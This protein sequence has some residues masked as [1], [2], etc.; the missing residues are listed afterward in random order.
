MS[1]TAFLAVVCGCCLATT[2]SAD[3]PAPGEIA[4]QIDQSLTKEVFTDPTK[5][6]PRADDATFLR[7]VWLDIAGDIPTAEQVTAF[8]LDPSADKRERLVDQLLGDPHYGQNWARYWRDVV[9]FRALEEQSQLAAPAMEAD[10]TQWLNENRPWDKIAAEFITARGDVRKNGATALMMAQNG[11]TEEVT[12]EVSR[13]FLGI[14]LQCAQCHDHPYD[15]WKRE[16]FHELAAFFPRLAVRPVRSLSQRSFEVVGVDRFGLRPPK[17]ERFPTA[18]HM[19]PDLEHPDA[20]GT[21]ME[22]KFFLTG[23][24]VPWGTDDAER[25]RRLAHWLTGNPWFSMAVVNRM[26]AE[27]VGEGFYPNVEDIGPEREATVAATSDLLSRE[28]QKS[29]HDL[30]WLVQTICLTEAY[31]RESRPRRD[32]E[33][34]PFAANVPQRLR[35]DQLYNA[36]L[37]AFD[38]AEAPQARFRP[39]VGSRGPR[40]RFADVLAYD[41]SL[42]R[43]EIASSIPQVLAMMNSADVERMLAANRA[44][45][46]NRLITE[47]PTDDGLT[48]ELYLRCLGRLP[49]EAELATVADYRKEAQNRKETFEDLAWSLVNSAEFQHRR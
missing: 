4:R 40:G 6:A 15:D 30:K 5:L 36:L 48:T 25:R 26:W 47:L 9:F 19:M 33:G 46:L 24:T 12:A 7:R 29:G 44:S 39:G 21:K 2:T 41:P 45:T 28:F 38:V 49:T 18:E 16:Q 37:T 31:Q 14:Q 34:T 32:S 23:A 20:P 1:R 17:N 27:M 35:S 42:A 10:L 43:E 8:L 11:Q 22:A 3:Q 13:I